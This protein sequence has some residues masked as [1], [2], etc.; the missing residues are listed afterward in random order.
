MKTRSATV[1]QGRQR[2]RVERH[3]VAANLEVQVRAAGAPAGA[4]IADDLVLPHLAADF[5]MSGVAGQVGVGFA[6]VSWT[7]RMRGVERRE[8]SVDEAEAV[9][10]L[11]RG[12]QAGSRTRFRASMSRKAPSPWPLL[13]SSTASRPSNTAGTG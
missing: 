5:E 10:A 3:A 1:R 2:K 4:D 12:V 9:Q 13:P 6:L 7:P 8:V 11:Q